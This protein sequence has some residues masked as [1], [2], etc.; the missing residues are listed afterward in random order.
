MILRSLIGRFAVVLVSMVVMV[1]VVWA[2]KPNI[3]TAS[4]MENLLGEQASAASLE[5]KF[6]QSKYIADLDTSLDSS[7]HFSFVVDEGLS[8]NIR[9]PVATNLRIT[10]NEIVEE[11][12]GEVV[13]RMGV[14]EQPMTRAIS[15]VFFAIFGGDWQALEERFTIHSVQEDARWIVELE[16]KDELLKSYLNAIKLQ[17]SDYLEVL[18][19]SESN[20]DRT[21]IDLNDIKAR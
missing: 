17:G 4:A 11:Q 6:E 7:G 9:K 21:R 8:W 16:P 1:S 14:D 18:I 12:D 20:G 13:M 15:E 3:E 2:A 5:G 19:L 10:P